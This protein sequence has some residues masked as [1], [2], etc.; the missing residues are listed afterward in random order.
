MT[1]DGRLVSHTNTFTTFSTT[2]KNVAEDDAGAYNDWLTLLPP[3]PEGMESK[4]KVAVAYTGK[5]E[6]RVLDTSKAVEKVVL[7]GI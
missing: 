1:T 4:V 2:V 6:Q 3:L 5:G 7:S